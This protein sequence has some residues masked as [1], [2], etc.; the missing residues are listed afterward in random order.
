MDLLIIS[1]QEEILNTTNVD[2]IECDGID[3][4]FQ[5]L[6]NH[7]TMLNVLKNGK[8]RYKINNEE[9][10]IDFGKENAIL[11]VENNKVVILL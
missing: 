10:N 3:G 11:K 5:I 4:K 7:A 1:P 8:I 9:K 6:N 2:L